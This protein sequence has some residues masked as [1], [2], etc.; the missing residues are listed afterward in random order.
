[1]R[2]KHSLITPASGLYAKYPSMTTSIQVNNFLSVLGNRLICSCFGD[3]WSW[4]HGG[5]IDTKMQLARCYWMSHQISTKE[6][7]QSCCKVQTVKELGGNG[8]TPVY[9]TIP[10]LPMKWRI[11]SKSSAYNLANCNHIANFW[12]VCIPMTLFYGYIRASYTDC[13]YVA[14]LIAHIFS[15]KPKVIRAKFITQTTIFGACF[16]DYV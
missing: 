4:N 10:E 14:Q 7:F 3:I 9:E 2:N 13:C 5:L 12:V 11:M 6:Y 15:S 1:M 16:W 8:H